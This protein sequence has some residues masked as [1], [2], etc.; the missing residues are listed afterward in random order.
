MIQ[1]SPSI[2]A[3]NDYPTSP[4]LI[5][6]LAFNSAFAV[7]E[8]DEISSVSPLTVPGAMTLEEARNSDE[9]RFANSYT[10]LGA[11]LRLENNLSR[12]DFLRLL[13]EHWT[14]CD[15]IRA[16][17]KDLRRI[18]G[19]FGPL[20]EMMN[21]VENAAYDNLRGNSSNI[22]TI[23]RGC[24]RLNQNG[25]S[26]TVNKDTAKRFPFLNR[27]RCAN[28]RVVTA[29]VLKEQIL[30]VKLD[31]TE[32]EVI[33]FAAIPKKWERAVNPFQSEEGES[34]NSYLG[35]KL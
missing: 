20:R 19:K 10:R 15:N 14:G 28:P 9:I 13:G 26:W 3:Q 12:S 21:E 22:V 23:Y 24:N 2:P 17:R 5:Q 11:V 34:P 6:P 32:E 35:R 27:Y 25:I 18:L 8:I 29:T 16:Y 31:R 7:I 4:E 1:N 30:A 33:T